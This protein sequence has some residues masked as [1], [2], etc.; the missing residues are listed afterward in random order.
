MGHHFSSIAGAGPITAATT[1][2]G[3]LSCVLWIMIASVAP[4]WILLQPRD[5][6]SSFLLYA[7]LALAA[8]CADWGPWA[9]AILDIL[10]MVLAVVLVIEGVQT[11]F[12]K[13]KKEAAK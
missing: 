12:F 4:V 3:W 2:F 5:Y 7:M 11:I 8:G 6:L 1:G 10:L 9:Q 13:N